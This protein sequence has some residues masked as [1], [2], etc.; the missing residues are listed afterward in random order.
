MVTKKIASGLKRNVVPDRIDLRDRPYQPTVAVI[1]GASLEPKTDI[2]VLFQGDSNACTGFSLASVIYHLQHT[3]KR[4]PAQCGVSPFMLY[5]MARRYDEFPGDST[6]DTGSS[7]RGAM[8]GWYKHGACASKLWTT[9]P[10]PSAP[11]KKTSDDWWLDAVL[12]PLG[13]YYRVDT[14]SITDMH[15]ALNEVGILYAS[16]VCHSGWDEGFAVKFKPNGQARSP[17]SSSLPQAGERDNVSLRKSHVNTR[18]WTIPPQKATPADGGHAFAIVGYNSDGFIIQNSWDTGWGSAGRAVL[19]YEDWLDNAMDCWV[20]QLGVVTDLHREIAQASTLRLRAGKVQL[21]S[22]PSLRKR[23][24]SPFIIDME[25]NGRLSN[26][27]EFRTRDSDIEALVNLHLGEARKAWKLGKNDA[28]DIAIYAHGGLTSE[29]DAAAT[30][31]KWIPALYDQQIFPIFLMWETDLWSTLSNRLEDTLRGQPRPTG[32]LFD[33][34]R[35]WWNERLEKLLAKPGTTIWGEMKQN[36]EAISGAKDS[37]GVKLFEA[38]KKS[39]HFADLT[40]VRLHLI[41]HSAG[42][43]LHSHAIERLCG[44]GWIFDSVNFMAPAVRLDTF[45]AKVVPAIKNKQVKRYNQFHLSD[46]IEQKDP[47][48]KGMLGYSRSLLYLVSQ[49]FEKGEVTP[50]L[51]MEKYFNEKIAPQKLKTVRIWAAPGK[52]SQSATHGGFDDDGATMK[53]VIGLIRED[54]L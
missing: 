52:E 6:A 45:Q 31:A 9:E 34:V 44:D 38:C 18:W 10:M 37:G 13:A 15:V 40:K 3:A 12:R 16:A 46:D 19:G 17:L 7:L 4:N 8:K 21:A 47:T 54:V 22:E 1:P 51:G 42:A 53:S 20:A 35:G 24:I 23:E 5:S 49:S 39:P 48:C 32:G 43:I 29:S 33:N 50:I 28:V 25:N 36:A 41:G 14:R 26:T 2:P 30:A 11:V 27:G